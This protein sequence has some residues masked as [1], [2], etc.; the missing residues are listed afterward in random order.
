MTLILGQMAPQPLSNECW[1]RPWGPF[2]NQ[3]WLLFMLGVHWVFRVIPLL[4][5]I[6]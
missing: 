3:S 4:S 5:H 1:G 2:L 6:P